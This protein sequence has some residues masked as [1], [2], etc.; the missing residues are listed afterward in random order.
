MAAK[1]KQALNGG[2]C[3]R[4]RLRLTPMKI[5]LC[6]AGMRYNTSRLAFSGPLCDL[7]IYTLLCIKS[8]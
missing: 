5:P 3:P 2:K 7:C 4:K 1:Q 6:K 8:D